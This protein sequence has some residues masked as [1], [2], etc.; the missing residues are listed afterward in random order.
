ME[1]IGGF[2]VEWGM[3]L[4]FCFLFVCC[5]VGCILAGFVTLIGFVVPDVACFINFLT[6]G[7]AY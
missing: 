3:G 6:G 4:L 7:V 2:G 5:S 1:W